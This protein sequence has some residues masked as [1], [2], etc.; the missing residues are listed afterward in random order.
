MLRLSS[1]SSKSAK[2]SAARRRAE[3]SGPLSDAEQV[4]HREAATAGRQLVEGAEEEVL[5][6]PGAVGAG[7]QKEQRTLPLTE[8]GG[9][10]DLEPHGPTAAAGHPHR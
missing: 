3:A 7:P 10:P 4:A 6:S 2:G 8:G 9:A 1:G 5:Y